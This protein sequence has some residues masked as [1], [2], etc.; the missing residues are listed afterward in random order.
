MVAT[1]CRSFRAHHTIL[2][3]GALD[4]VA[5]AM[6]YSIDEAQIASAMIDRSRKSCIGR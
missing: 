1:Q 3:I 6:Q 5:G 2:T 4:E